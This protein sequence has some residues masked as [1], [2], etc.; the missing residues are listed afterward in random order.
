MSE[1]GQWLREA[2]QAKELSLEQAEAE[3]RI[4]SHFLAA[5][6]EDNYDDLPAEVHTKGFLRNY[7]L[8]LGLDPAE[9]LE[10]YS[11]KDTSQLTREPGL[12]RPLEVGLFRATGGWLRFRL[13]VLVLVVALL[14]VVLWAWRTGR[15][16][17]PLPLA[18]FQPTAT[19]TTTPR[20]SHTP[21]SVSQLL[22]TATKRATATPE[23]TATRLPS[24]TWTTSAPPEPTST[25]VPSP[26]PTPTIEPP[27]PTATRA[28]ATAQPTAEPTSEPVT[29]SVT[30][31]P[32][33][34]VTLSITATEECWTEVTLDSLN[35]FRGLVGAG[36]QL[37]WQA[38]REII[39]RLGNAGA[40]EVTVNGEFLGTLG[41]RQQVVEFAWGPEGEVTPEPTATATATTEGTPEE[42][43]ATATPTPETQ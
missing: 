24:P 32:G 16:V 11:T 43:T 13:L 4:R 36:E 29:P 37:A 28:R 17:W 33:I 9:A 23:T 8:F 30:L 31:E 15:L 3:T 2:R 21:T 38:Q 10:K 6:E 40:V 34:G 1:L 22:A 35:A 39:L 14:T 12:F 18:L 19:S 7:A 41:D 26:T 27:T 5:L 20:P 42:P 25:V